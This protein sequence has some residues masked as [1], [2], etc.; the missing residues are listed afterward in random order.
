V[1]SCCVSSRTWLPRRQD[2]P[3]RVPLGRSARSSAR[4][5]TSVPISSWRGVSPTCWTLAGL[6]GHDSQRRPARDDRTHRGRS[7]AQERA[8]LKPLPAERFDAVL[9]IERRVSHEGMVSVGTNL[10]SVPD[11]N[12]GGALAEVETTADQSASE[13]PTVQH[14]GGNTKPVPRRS[15]RRGRRL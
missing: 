1:P 4:T 8:D 5:A 11:E 9:R 13:R 12:R 10:Y 2:G 15:R 6:A 3:D 14:L 7:L